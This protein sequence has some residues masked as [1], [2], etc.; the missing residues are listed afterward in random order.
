M[1]D[2]R[3]EEAQRRPRWQASGSGSGSGSGSFVA[4]FDQPLAVLYHC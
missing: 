3:C 4:G 1:M 2:R